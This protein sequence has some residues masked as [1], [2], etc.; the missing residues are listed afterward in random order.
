MPMQGLGSDRVV[1]GT[2]TG[3]DPQFCV[4]VVTICFD[5]KAAG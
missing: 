5:S 2:D 3:K 1:W 4:H